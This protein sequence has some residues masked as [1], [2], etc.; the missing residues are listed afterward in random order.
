M[1]W[2][3]GIL[4]MLAVA[5][6]IQSGLLGYCQIGPTVLESGDLFG[7]HRRYRVVTEPVYVLVYPKVVPLRG[8]DVASRRPIGDIRLTHRLYEDPTRIAGVRAYQPGDPLNR[9]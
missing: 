4:L 7:L 5:L 9:I 3:L 1:R 6:A 8:Y 2:F